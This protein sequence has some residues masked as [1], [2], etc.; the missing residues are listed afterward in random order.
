MHI[1]TFSIQELAD[2]L[3]V[4][5]I[6]TTTTHAGILTHTIKHPNLGNVITVQSDNGGLVISSL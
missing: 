2:I 5:T 4:S 6:I 3:E 1:A